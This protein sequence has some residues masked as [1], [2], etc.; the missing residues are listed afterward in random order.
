VQLEQ[1]AKSDIDGYEAEERGFLDGC[2]RQ[3]WSNVYERNP[4]L[5]AQAIA[6]HGTKCAVC[7][8]DFE[9]TYGVRGRGYIEAHHLYPVSSRGGPTEVDPRTEMTVV[10][11]NCHRMIHRNKD[12][13]LSIPE[14]RR[15]L[16][17]PRKEP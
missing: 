12:K 11:S 4:K 8:F 14:M 7:G 6:Y 2:K 3:H 15:I 5:R 1:V 16:K 10:C 9:A 13:V 17:R